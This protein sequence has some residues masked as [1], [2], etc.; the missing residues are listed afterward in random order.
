MNI[1]TILQKVAKEGLMCHVDGNTLNN[2]R[3]NL[4][5]VTVLQA[6]QHKDWTVDA[7]CTPD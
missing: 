1:T 6:F 4:Q 2:T 7:V 5:W 3:E